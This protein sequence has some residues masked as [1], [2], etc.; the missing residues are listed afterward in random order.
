M[1]EALAACQMLGYFRT[2]LLSVLLIC[3]KVILSRR[4]TR[5]PVPKLNKVIKTN[6]LF[7]VHG[8]VITTS[9]VAYTLR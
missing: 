5:T 9:V 8:Y 7:D 3:S 4:T 1:T 6:V 2:S